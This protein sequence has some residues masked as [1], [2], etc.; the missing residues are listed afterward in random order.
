MIKQFSKILIPLSIL[1]IVGF[2]L[3]VIN[4]ISGVYLLVRSSS[5]L[6]ANILLAFLSILAFGLF[7]WPLVLYL[8]LPTP[9]NIPKNNK[10]LA[11]Y[12]KN[13]VK[14]LRSNQH[15]KRAGLIPKDVDMLPE[16]IN[17]LNKEASKVIRDTANIVFLT[18]S[19]SQNGKL[20][21]FTVLMTQSRM[22]W[23]IAHLYYQRPTL[24]EMTY[25]YANVGAS[26][27]LAS[28]IED[29]D[30][31]TQIEPV[32]QSFF[33]NSAGKSIPLIGP[34]ANIILDSLMEGSTNAFL[35]LRVGN[36]A[37][38]Y[39]SC[40]EVTTKE[41]IKKLAFSESVSQLKEIVLKSS[42]RI[43]TGLLKATKKAGT[44]TLKSGW[45]AI[46]TAGGKI[47]EGVRKQGQKVTSLGRKTAKQ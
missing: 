4:Q 14:R 37:S 38:K 11:K 31:S 6:Y 46:S 5:E 29:L 40:Y 45:E 17:Y 27:L 20:D 42:A 32:L 47:Y 22:V 3:F 12:Q 21:A 2:V 39:C 23:K 13:L 9:L 34:T 43:F 24:R 19:V 10:E 36:I 25:L 18:T 7:A 30:I 44:D 26:T 15:L 33:R 28:E 8:K 35:T 16:A 41:K 1:L